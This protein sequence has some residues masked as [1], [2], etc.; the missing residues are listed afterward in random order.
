MQLFDFAKIIK[1]FLFK[2]KKVNKKIMKI[3]L[4]FSFFA[5]SIQEWVLSLSKV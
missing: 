2:I 3:N 5:G 4:R 1:K